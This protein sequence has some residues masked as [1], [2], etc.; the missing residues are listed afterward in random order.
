MCHFTS[1]T[2]ALLRDAANRASIVIYQNWSK[3]TICAMHAS[4]FGSRKFHLASSMCGI[5]FPVLGTRSPASWMFPLTMPCPHLKGGRK[6]KLQASALS[7]QKV[8]P[9]H[10]L[11]AEIQTMSPRDAFRSHR[12]PPVPETFPESATA[13]G[14]QREGDKKEEDERP[15][16][17][18]LP[19]I[20]S[21]VPLPRRSSPHLLPSRIIPLRRQLSIHDLAEAA[22]S[23]HAR[24]SSIPA[25]DRTSNIPAR[26][27]PFAG[28]K[29]NL[30]REELCIKAAKMVWDDLSQVLIWPMNDIDWS[31]EAMCERVTDL[32]VF[33]LP[34]SL[35]FAVLTVSAWARPSWR[36]NC[37][38]ETIHR[39]EF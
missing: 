19:R 20:G 14:R 3:R 36:E 27:D 2:A 30:D 24:A 25:R 29:L 11:L 22:S 17:P 12:T 10:L 5:S 26:E 15:S 23:R 1:I 9:V 32:V 34:M 31:D 39:R 7:T 13:R 16:S 33:Y 21:P 38:R 18:P 8:V 37:D 6:W 35:I 4:E 28:M